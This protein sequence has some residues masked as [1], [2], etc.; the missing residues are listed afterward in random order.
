M[1]VFTL[2]SGQ[3]VRHEPT[4]ELICTACRLH[5]DMDTLGQC[6]GGTILFAFY[7]PKYVHGLYRTYW[8]LHRR[9]TSFQDTL[10]T[11]RAEAWDSYPLIWVLGLEDYKGKDGPLNVYFRR[12]LPRGAYDKM[13]QQ[14]LPAIRQYMHPR[15]YK[16]PSQIPQERD[17]HVYVVQAETTSFVKIGYSQKKYVRLKSLQTASPFPLTVLRL[18]PT[19]KALSLERLLHYRYA[20]YRHQGEWFALPPDVLQDLLQEEFSP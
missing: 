18:I 2:E 11:I 5:L 8:Y 9:C 13:Y 12:H 16:Q 6:P 10:N 17:G 19:A 4:N 3:H 1:P 7:F 20:C 14:W 15:W